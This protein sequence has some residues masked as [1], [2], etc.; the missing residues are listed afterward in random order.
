MLKITKLYTFLSP[1]YINIYSFVYKRRD[2]RTVDEGEGVAED[3][4]E[5]KC[6]LEGLTVWNAPRRESPFPNSSVSRETGFSLLL[7][8]LSCR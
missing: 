4:A 1:N 7:E 8:A 2:G 5:N 3:L 6:L